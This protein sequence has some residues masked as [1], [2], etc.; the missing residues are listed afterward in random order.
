MEPHGVGFARADRPRVRDRRRARRAGRDARA[1]GARVRARPRRWRGGWCPE[2]WA[3][4]GRGA[5]R[6]LAARA[7]RV[8]DDHAGRPGR[9]AAGGRGAVRA[10]G[11]RAP[12]AALRVRRRAAARRAAVAG[13][14]VRGA[15]AWSSPGRWSTWTLRER[16]RLAALVAGEA[17]AASLVFYATINDR[18]YGGLTPRAAGTAGAARV[19]ARLRRAAAAARRAVAGPRRRACC[20]GRRCWR[21]C[22]SPAGCCTARAATS[23][24]ASR[25]RGAR[26]RRAP[27]C[28]SASSARSCVVV[29]LLSTGGLRGA[30]FPGVPLVAVL[31]AVAALTAWGLRHVPRLL[32]ALLALFTLGASTWLRAGR[33]PRPPRRAGSRSTPTRP[34]GPPVVVFPNFTG[35]ALWPALAV[36]AARRGRGA[37]CGGAS[38]ARRASGG[39]RPPPRARRRRCTERW[40]ACDRT[41]APDVRARAGPRHPRPRCATPRARGRRRRARRARRGAARAA[42]AAHPRRA[43]RRPSPR[44]TRCPEEGAPL[45]QRARRPRGRARRRHAARR[46]ADGRAPAPRAA[47]R[48]RGGRAGGRA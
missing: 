26:P 44:S 32:A 22:S 10:G 2:P 42:L 14:D 41:R 20:A 4:V 33:A 6:P 3:T 40:H 11:A 24:R 18:F 21:S 16:R 28:C 17:L 25:R 48:R 47:D 39:A 13:L 1:A 31:P 30:T 43:R 5:R 8:D 36:R 46:P 27:G 12:A 9:G 45:E 15:R 35:A 23:S 7:R 37:S 29:A 34:W 38:A 19:P